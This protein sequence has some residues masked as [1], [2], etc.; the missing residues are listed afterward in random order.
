MSDQEKMST[1]VAI[2][3]TLEA[4][5]EIMGDKGAKIIFR[6]A[7]LAHIFE[8][9]PDYSFAPC[10]T[11]RDQARILFEVE[12]LVGLTGAL[13]IWRRIG[14]TV[15]R[16]AEE[17]GRV[18]DSLKGLSPDERF[19]KSLEILSAASG[20]GRPVVR[21]SGEVNFDNFNCQLCEGRKMNR[22][23][24]SFYEGVTQH[25]LDLAYGRGEYIAQ[26]TKC[27]GVGD[28]TCF[29][30]FSKK[31]DNAVVLKIRIQH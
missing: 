24:C 3:S 29:Y 31:S 6:S 1:N 14:F 22:P 15:I 7:D 26:E 9:P 10:I 30:T 23:M 16:Y 13:G 18:G 11:V 5:T 20:R 2:R 21:E 12:N 8:T 27:M 25:L 28:D 4:I 19:L 17:V